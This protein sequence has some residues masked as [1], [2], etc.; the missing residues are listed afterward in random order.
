MENG[1]R[2]Y[3]NKVFL[4]MILGILIT[5]FTGYIVSTDIILLSIFL[6]GFYFFL[7]AEIILVFTFVSIIHKVKPTTAIIM[8]IIY[9]LMNGITFSGI[10][11]V[12]KLGSILIIFLL[13]SIFFILL[14]L[15]GYLTKQDLTRLG[16]I[17]LIGLISI[18]I[19]SIFGFL[20]RLSGLEVIISIII[21]VIFSG[22]TAY[23]IQKIKN[24]Y[25]IDSNVYKTNIAIYGALQLYLDFI[26]I[27]IRLLSLFGRGRD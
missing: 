16:S 21:I 10:F 13:T 4:W 27:F 24:N 22:L 15:Y 12:Y 6:K 8:F 26:N 14:C 3:V 20:F 9:A 1:I 7:I 5:G 2:D 23:D 25:D 18:I 11:L 19:I 17:M